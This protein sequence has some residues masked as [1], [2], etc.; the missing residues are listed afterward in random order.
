M[1]L[2]IRGLNGP[3]AEAVW[4]AL[5][6]YVENT[7]EAEEQNPGSCALLEPA[8]ALLGKINW[9]VASLTDD[10][11]KREARPQQVV[12]ASWVLGQLAGN[13]LHRGG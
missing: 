3:E 2:A 7:T 4:E 1:I 11:P 5:G 13:A 6:Q 12:S 10:T 9:A 8:E